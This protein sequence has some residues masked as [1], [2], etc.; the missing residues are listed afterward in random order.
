MISLPDNY[1]EVSFHEDNIVASPSIKRNKCKT[2]VQQLGPKRS[3][4]LKSIHNGF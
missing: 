3:E 4:R 1:N 2:L